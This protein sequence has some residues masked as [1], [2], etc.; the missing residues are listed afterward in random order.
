[1]SRFL[2]DPYDATLDLQNKEN[3]KLFQDACRGLKE[4]DHFGGKRETYS[5]FMKLV[6]K[7]F[8]STR[9]M[10]ALLIPTQWNTAASTPEE[11]RKVLVAST[12]YVFSSNKITR[13]QI[14][15]L[16][17]RVWQD[18]SLND[19]GHKF[20]EHFDTAP[21]TEDELNL[22]KHKRRLKHVMMG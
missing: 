21:T 2:L 16:S 7:A 1:M 19:P 6:E 11:Q 9:V 8:V 3:R 4:K 12:V 20:L 15:N 22:A 18:T 14:T 13:E 5:D 17:N 10:E